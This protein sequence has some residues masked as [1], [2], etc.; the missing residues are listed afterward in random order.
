[1]ALD[2]QKKN[3]MKKLNSWVEID[4]A[5]Y[6]WYILQG[7]DIDVDETTVMWI[8][9]GKLHRTDGPAVIWADGTRVWLVDGKKHRTDGPA[10]IKEDGTRMWLVDGKLHRTDG[11]AVIWADG[12]QAWWINGTQYTEEQFNEIKRNAM[13]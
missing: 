4:E 10:L 8:L 5:R 3:S 12:T 2:I 6:M 13:A 11:P 1:M 7:Y 9:D